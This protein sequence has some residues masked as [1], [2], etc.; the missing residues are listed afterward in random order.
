MNQA[1]FKVGPHTFSMQNSPTGV[2][3]IFCGE[4]LLSKERSLLGGALHKFTY[5]GD[6]YEVKVK[7]GIVQKSVAAKLSD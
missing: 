3:E 2:E 5:E 1:E 6:D 7:A 4:E